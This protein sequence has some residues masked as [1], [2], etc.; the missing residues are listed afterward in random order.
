M[1]LPAFKILKTIAKK[2]ELKLREVLNLVPRKYGD[3]RDLY[4]LASLFTGGYVSLNLD[5]KR[6][7]SDLTRNDRVSRMFYT[8]SLGPGEFEYDGVG[9]INDTD[10]NDALRFSS[11]AKTDIHFAESRAKK[12]ERVITVLIACCIAIFTVVVTEYVKAYI[13]RL[14]PEF[15]HHWSDS[16]GSGLSGHE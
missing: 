9:T 2:R 10:F 5:L 13:H 3:H 16:K 4:P 11:T 6:T 12:W 14:N 1:K 7:D 15:F 8:M